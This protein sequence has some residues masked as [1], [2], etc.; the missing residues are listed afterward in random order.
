MCGLLESG[1]FTQVLLYVLS[2]DSAQSG[3]SLSLINVQSVTKDPEFFMWT[4]QTELMPR[5]I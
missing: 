5:M 2:E 1:H 3:H 4:V